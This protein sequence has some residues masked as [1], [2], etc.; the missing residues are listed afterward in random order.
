MRTVVLLSDGP[1]FRFGASFSIPTPRPPVQLVGYLAAH[2]WKIAPRMVLWMTTDQLRHA[3]RR[4]RFPVDRGQ[5]VRSRGEVPGYKYD[6]AAEWQ[7]QRPNCPLPLPS[8]WLA[9]ERPTV[10]ESLQHALTFGL[11]HTYKRSSKR[12][13]QKPYDAYEYLT[14]DIDYIF[15]NP[16][17]GPFRSSGIRD[18][19]C[20]PV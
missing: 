9:R 19:R 15:D 7:G 6:L 12:I 10:I 20:R 18:S 4:G 1:V 3:R 2:R 16:S 17:A 8:G 14:R 11:E 13:R 5:G